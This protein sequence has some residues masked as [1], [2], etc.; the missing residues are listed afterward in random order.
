MRI[1]GQIDLFTYLDH[2]DVDFGG[3]Y[4]CICKTCLF[5]ESGRCVY[6]ECYD[7]KRVKENP[8]DKAH[9]NNPVRKSWSNWNKPNEQKH[10]C[11]G[12]V[13]YSAK[14]CDRYVRY[15][16]VDIQECI[17][18]N[19]VVY[20]DGFINCLIKEAMGCQ[21]C[22]EEQEG[23]LREE[24]YGCRWMTENG[25][26]AHINA[27]SLLLDDILGGSEESPCNRQCCI[28][29]ERRSNCGYACGVC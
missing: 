17:A 21:A 10:W 4:N 23:R 9:P 7:D 25:C 29:C 15:T 6:G 19:I 2:S 28:G 3:C 16:S 24:V 5:H 26:S 11:R 22:I 13:F 20:Q 1:A 18:C 12:G 14:Y 27:Q 8:Y